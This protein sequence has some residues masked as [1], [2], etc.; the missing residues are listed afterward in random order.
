MTNKKI[1]FYDG[2][3]NLCNGFVK[4]IINLDKKNIFLFA[5]LNGNHA[6]NL[7]KDINLDSKKLDSVI[8]YENKKISFKSKA[9]IEILLSLKGFFYLFWFAKIIPSFLSN[10]VY[11]FIAKN[12]YFWFGKQKNCIVPDK[13]ITSKFLD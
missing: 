11:N 9:I 3:C 10:I 2:F 1:I 4:T 5:P 12:R 8:L 13:K 7:L 6:K